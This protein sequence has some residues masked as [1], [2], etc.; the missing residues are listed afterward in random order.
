ML[1]KSL[2]AGV[3]AGIASAVL[4]LSVSTGTFIGVF[5]LFLLAPLPITIA[6]FGWGSISAGV[7]ALA[8]DSVVAIVGAPRPALL[9]LAAFGFPAALLSFLTLLRRKTADDA[10]RQSAAWYPIG[11]VLAWLA[12]LA[13]LLAVLGLLSTATSVEGLRNVMRGVL[14]HMLASGNGPPGL[15][16][17]LDGAQTTIIVEVL[18]AAMIWT[19]APMIMA[20]TG[21]NLWAGAHVSRISGRL[22]R[23]WP[24]L[25]AIVL[26]RL[27][28]A[29][30]SAA[31]VASFFTG[32]PG[33]IGA[34]VAS[35]FLFAYTLVGLAIVHHVTRGLPVRPIVLA[36]VY[37]ALLFLFVPA[38]PVLALLGIAEPF[39]PLKR[40]S[41]I[42]A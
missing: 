16:T 10:Q 25:A 13:G 30:L 31:I 7:A 19:T 22:E 5:V 37:T 21:F 40:R 6:G 35:A 32:I 26:P 20:I 36:L 17:Q 38:A 1:W 28:P 23:P 8:G 27:V 3:G 14:D 18:V 24:D 39:S 41:L 34:S 12:A 29:L 15:D 4:F 11:S 2:L 9:Y 42:P 33:I